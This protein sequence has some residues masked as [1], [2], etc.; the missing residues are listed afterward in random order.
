MNVFPLFRF[1]THDEVSEAKM[2]DKENIVNQV[3][4]ML[5]KFTHEYPYTQQQQYLTDEDW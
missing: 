4:T 3:G 2:I 5:M 1:Y